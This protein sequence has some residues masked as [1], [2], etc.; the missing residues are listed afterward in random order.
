MTKQGVKLCYNCGGE[1]ER[2]VVRLVETA[3]NGEPVLINSVPAKV[4]VRCGAKVYSSQVAQEL[5]RIL[6]G[7]RE[8]SESITL[9]MPSYDL[10]TA[11][12]R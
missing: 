4:C 12:V 8:S 3:A 6:N 9:N 1:L 5:L 10:E 7:E 11:D 2:R